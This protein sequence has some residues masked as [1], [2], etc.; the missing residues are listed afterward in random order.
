[1]KQKASPSPYRSRSSGVAL[2]ITLAMLVLLSGLILAFYSTVTTDVAGSKAYEGGADARMVADSAVNL[3][4]G[5]IRDASTQNNVA[6]ISQPGLMRTFDA[7]GNALRAYKLYSSDQLVIDG[8][9]DPTNNPDDV[10]TTADWRNQT[11]LWTDLNSPVADPTRQGPKN[12]PLLT[13]P[14]LDGNYLQTGS[15][16]SASG[17]VGQLAF[18]LDGKGPDITS[19]EIQNFDKQHPC[20]M[21]VKWMYLLKDGTLVAAAT[22]SQ[23]SSAKLQIP[24]GKEKTP[25][26][27]PNEPVARVA[28]WTD[29]ETAKVN[30]NTASEGTFWD[31][32]VCVTQ[33]NYLPPKPPPAGSID[34]NTMYEMD[35]AEYEP[36]Q[37]EYQRFPGHPATTCLSPIFGKQLTLLHPYR[38]D[39]IEAIYEMAPR[40]AGWNYTGY[41]PSY[42]NAGVNGDYSSDG[43][44]RRA[45]K[46]VM[47]AG[48]AG[49]YPVKLD[50]DRLYASVDELLFSPI[51]K[52]VGSG[53]A[54]RQEQN[55]APKNAAIDNN[56]EMLEMAKFFI[57]PNSHA[58]EQNL[59]NKPR[60][61]IWP[62]DI[63]DKYRTQY[64]RA[65]AFCS[66][67][68]PAKAATERVPFYFTRQSENGAG[69]A[70][71]TLDFS[72]RNKQVYTY[73]QKLMNI[74]APGYPMTGG[75]SNFWA[76]YNDDSDQILTEIYDYIRCTNLIDRSEGPGKA[77]TPLDDEYAHDGLTRRG[78]VVPIVINSGKEMTR[79]I[80]RIA[81]VS[82]LAL[83]LVKMD[84]SLIPPNSPQNSIYI[85]AA[86][87]PELFCPMAGYSALANNI[88]LKFSSIKLNISD[89]SGTPTPPFPASQ[90]DL[91]DI[92][93]VTEIEDNE[94]KIGGYIGTRSLL[95]WNTTDQGKYPTYRWPQNVGA[96]KTSAPPTNDFLITKPKGGTGSLQIEGSVVIE[97][98][99]PVSLGDPA[100][101]VPDPS[102]EFVIQ[103]LTFNFPKTTVPFPSTNDFSTFT[104]GSGSSSKQG[105]KRNPVDNT[106][107]AT[108]NRCHSSGGQWDVMFHGGDV[109]RSSSC[110]GDSY[111]G[112]MRLVAAMDKVDKSPR[113]SSIM[114]AIKP[115]GGAANSYFDGSTQNIHTMRPCWATTYPGFRQNWLVPSLTGYGGAGT[116]IHPSVPIGVDP[117]KGV[118]NVKTGYPGDWD[119][120][121][122]WVIDGP[123]CNKADEGTRRHEHGRGGSGGQFDEDSAPYIGWYWNPQ[124]AITEQA[125]Y[126]SPNRQMASA[127][128]FGSLPTGVKRG[129]PW[130]TLLFR[131]AKEYFPGGKSHPGGADSGPPD[132][133]L[134]DLFWMPVVEPYPISEP[135]A[136]AGKINLNAQIVPFTNVK[137]YTGLRAI[138]QSVKITAQNPRQSDSNCDLI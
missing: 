62:V 22:G 25:E 85:E 107:D 83:V 80:G 42:S 84:D 28:F 64:D 60:V 131:P 19:F 40:V 59:F 103:T 30:I 128:T 102:K 23:A 7:N 130:Q 118:V 76:K 75:P 67:L 88:R 116:D 110:V 82:E 111:Q 122:A 44:T 119:N 68:P 87:I 99:G 58:P 57:T 3:V 117:A 63:S 29:D 15:D 70:S 9:F 133:L 54:Q 125:D 108:S 78:Q 79:G 37:K 2:I 123:L 113:G 114:T 89:Q 92:G 71:S 100:S 135:F 77:Y 138:M 27:E 127:V 8:T 81:T 17:P 14:I 96:P 94:S 126:F 112:D 18:T 6:W 46:G 48:D 134:L 36:G 124:D 120:G 65:I 34:P 4:I 45:G 121:P 49:I 38:P 53:P 98:R 32:P 13:Y 12:T 55:L 35:L 43:G 104:D 5:Q 1:M 109:V 129:L 50:S 73:L 90:P 101:S 105:R 95:Q 41:P 39:M 47:L 21:P 11:A 69:A 86:L 93:R 52:S 72:P 26:G 106:L 24:A 66:S 33:R 61:A 97:V 10:P 56:R 137:R 136:T 132:H 51:F 91:Y 115:R 74:R 16:P 20:E 31:T